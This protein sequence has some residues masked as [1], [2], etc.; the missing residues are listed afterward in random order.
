MLNKVFRKFKQQDHE[1]EKTI[2][3]KYYERVYYA[4]YYV[5][6]D[7]DLAQDILQ[8][9]FMKAF[10]NMHKVHDEEKIGA[11]LSTIA[12]RTA[13]DY[14]RRMK[15]RNEFVIED[16]LMDTEYVATYLDHIST[17]ETVLEEA[18]LKAILLEEI[19]KLKP[20]HREAVILYYLHDLRYEEIAELLDMNIATVKT[21]VFRA[22]KKLKES[23]EKQPELMEVLWNV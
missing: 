18:Q 6:K 16:V 22:K 10:K 2:F 11:W 8:E 23:I 5:I 19:D 15:K 4:A 20:D 1:A 12:T 14:Y 3:D 21:R 17:V 7:P 13:I 9:T